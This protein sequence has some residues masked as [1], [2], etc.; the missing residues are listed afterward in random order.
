METSTFVG[1]IAERLSA[2]NRL[3]K[4]GSGDLFLPHSV[5]TP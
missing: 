3:R 5:A 1:G 4:D 2:T